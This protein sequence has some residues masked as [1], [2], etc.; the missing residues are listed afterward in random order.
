MFTDQS[1]YTHDYV[2]EY[3]NCLLMTGQCVYVIMHISTSILYPM[4]MNGHFVYVIMSMSILVGRLCHRDGYRPH[5]PPYICHPGERVRYGMDQHEPQSRQP[6]SDVTIWTED[7][8]YCL[9][10]GLTGPLM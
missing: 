3:T 4:Y 8:D 5:K 6:A 9:R 7:A 10:Y 2:H 1:L